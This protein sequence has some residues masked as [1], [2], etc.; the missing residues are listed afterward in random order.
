MGVAVRVVVPGWGDGVEEEIIRDNELAATVT[1]KEHEVVS[2]LWDAADEAGSCV[3][4]Q[5][6]LTTLWAR[7]GTGHVAPPWE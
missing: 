6:R 3:T 2:S 4:A 5:E 7:T 1:A